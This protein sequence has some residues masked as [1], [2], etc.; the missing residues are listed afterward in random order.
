MR[1]RFQFQEQTSRTYSRATYSEIEYQ[2][3]SSILHIRF[4]VQNQEEV[5]N[6]LFVCFACFIDF[7]C[8]ITK[9]NILLCNN[10]Q[11]CVINSLESFDCVT[12]TLI[13]TREDCS[14]VNH[15]RFH[16]KASRNCCVQ[17]LVYIFDFIFFNICS[18]TS[19][20]LSHYR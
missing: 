17:L 6:H 10:L 3:E 5:S 14:Y 18:K 19:E 1:T 2:I 7:L 11:I 13:K 12:K 20:I 4:H 15:T 16:I 8:N 9:S